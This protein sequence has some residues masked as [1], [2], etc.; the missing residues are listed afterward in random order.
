[1]TNKQL[2]LLAWANIV[3]AG[4]PFE[5]WQIPDWAGGH[6]CKVTYPGHTPADFEYLRWAGT[7]LEYAQEAP[8]F[9]EAGQPFHGEA[10]EEVFSAAQLLEGYIKGWK[11]IGW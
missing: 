5:V 2:Q 10:W 7:P 1:M 6:Y 4:K 9:D 8:E 3:N 11:E